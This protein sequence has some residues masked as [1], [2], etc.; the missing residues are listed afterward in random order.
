[1]PYPQALAEDTKAF[2]GEK[3]LMWPQESQEFY[4]RTSV[5]MALLIADQNNNVQARCIGKWIGEHEKQAYDQIIE[6]ARLYPKYHPRG[7]ILAV[8]EKRC[9]AF[10][11][12]ADAN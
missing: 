7:I 2:T 11:Y 6:A 12:T 5:G 8:M 10:I 3:F 4:I 9:G 1:M